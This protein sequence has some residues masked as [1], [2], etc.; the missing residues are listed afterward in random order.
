MTRDQRVV[1]ITGAASGIGRAAAQLFS[2]TGAAIVAIDVDG[3]GV[4]TVA[5]EISAAGGEAVAHEVDISSEH[6]VRSMVDL[7]LDRYGRIDVLF[8]NAGIGPSASS[9]F[10]MASVVDTSEYAWDAI[11]A[12][13]LKGPFLTCKH[14][15]PVMVEQGCGVIINNSSINGL[16]AI[17][18]ADA[19][20]ASKGGLIALTRVL[21]SDWSAQGIR[22]NVICPGPV[23]TPMNRPWLE[24]PQKVTFFMDSCPMGRVASAEEIARVAVF[25]ASDAASYINGAVIPIDGGWTAR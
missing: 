12:I 22:V 25:L 13:N 8:N 17:P 3:P 21:A 9:R 19:Y 5:Q 14:V 10:Q 23:D 2:D 4:T 11:L 1:L 18:G 16:V 7:V 15:I 24:D 6:Q 20:T